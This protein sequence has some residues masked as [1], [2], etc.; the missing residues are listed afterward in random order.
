MI[1]LAENKILKENEILEG[2]F[3]I[4]ITSASFCIVAMKQVSLESGYTGENG[5]FF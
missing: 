5:C 2:N 4:P 3:L 1:I